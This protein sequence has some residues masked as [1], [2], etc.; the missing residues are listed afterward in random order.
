MERFGLSELQA[1]YILDTRLRQ[2]ARLEEMK[3]RAEQE[4]L[5]KE[6]DQ[7][8]K[9]LGSAVRLKN[10][11]RKELLAAADTYGDDR[12]SPL[13][14]RAEAQA[15]SETEL[16]SADPVTVVGAERGWI[17]AARGH[18]IDPARSEERRV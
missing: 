10:L 11:V 14:V 2:L 5:A 17:R 16:T 4:A 13:V 15:F 3:I 12:R 7:L 9:I 1:D 8:Q 6:R 18:D